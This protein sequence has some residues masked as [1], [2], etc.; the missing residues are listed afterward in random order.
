M[1][2]CQHAADVFSQKELGAELLQN[3]DIVKEQLTSGI[4]DASQGT[5][6]RPGLAGGTANDAIHFAV[7]EGRNIF[8]RDLT[9]VTL[10]QVGIGMIDSEGIEDSGVKFI[11]N[12]NMESGSFKAKVQTAA[13]A[14]QADYIHDLHLVVD[15]FQS[16]FDSNMLTRD[17]F[18]IPYTFICTVIYYY[19]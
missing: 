7:Q 15:Y 14:E 13:A 18:N 3:T 17:G 11:G 12:G 1:A 8:L 19:T 6:F 5:R 2:V 16:F 9:D 10:D 4:L